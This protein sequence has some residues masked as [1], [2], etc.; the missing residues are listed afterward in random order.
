MMQKKIL[1]ENLKILREF[2]YF[3]KK[4]INTICAINIAGIPNLKEFFLVLCLKA[5][6]PSSPPTEPPIADKMNSVFSEIRHLLFFAFFLSIAKTIKVI[7]LVS[8]R[9]EIKNFSILLSHFKIICC[10]GVFC[11]IYK[12]EGIC[13]VFV[14]EYR[15]TIISV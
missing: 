14:V 5:Y 4:Q 13:T 8:T 7:I 2:F 11:F 6:I 1:P 12:A 10:V 9:Y 15:I 3:A